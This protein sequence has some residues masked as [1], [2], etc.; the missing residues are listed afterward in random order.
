MKL[1]LIG[2]EFNVV[3]SRSESE[4][5]GLPIAYLDLLQI[6][7]DTTVLAGGSIVNPA[8]AASTLPRILILLDL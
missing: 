6:D 2:Y 5:H 7:L 1:L 4:R 3:C 8:V